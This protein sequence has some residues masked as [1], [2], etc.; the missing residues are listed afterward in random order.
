MDGPGLA[1]VLVAIVLLLLWLLFRQW[2]ANPVTFAAA[3]RYVGA[4][5]LT[6][7][8]LVLMRLLLR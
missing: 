2:R 5:V 4:L 7:L 1:A 8:A 3:L 6:A